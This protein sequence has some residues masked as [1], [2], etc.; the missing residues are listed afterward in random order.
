[1]CI[2]VYM[3]VCIY[4]HIITSVLWGKA[5]EEKKMRIVL[6]GARSGSCHSCGGSG[7]SLEEARNEQQLRE[8]LK[9]WGPASYASGRSKPGMQAE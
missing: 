4:R 5:E 2:G 3:H 6:A 8:E 1:M 9:M 7:L